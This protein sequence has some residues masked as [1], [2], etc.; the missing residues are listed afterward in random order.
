MIL[1]YREGMLIIYFKYT[2]T[3]LT[4]GSCISG[5]DSP[6]PTSWPF[7]LVAMTYDLVTLVISTVYLL[8]L[9]TYSGR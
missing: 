2:L 4:D 7:Y 3:Y 6:H 1:I 8:R 5:V 9:E